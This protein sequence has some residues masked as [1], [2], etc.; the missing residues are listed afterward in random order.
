MADQQIFISQPCMKSHSFRISTLSIFK[1]SST[2]CYPTAVQEVQYIH[3][4][5]SVNI[6]KGSSTSFS[7]TAIHKVPLAQNLCTVSF[8]CISTVFIYWDLIHGPPYF[9][10]MH[11]S[12]YATNEEGKIFQHAGLQ[13]FTPPSFTLL[14]QLPTASHNNN[15]N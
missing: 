4:L 6:L 3:N 5:Y 7:F 13:N 8:K 14:S 9:G 15:N 1:G 10:N 2:S 11:L 12:I